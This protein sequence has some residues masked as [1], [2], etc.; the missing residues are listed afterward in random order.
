[1]TNTI[2]D[3]TQDSEVIMLV[4]SN[5]EHAHPV[6]G[7]Q[8]R[9]AVQRGAKLIV[10]DPRDI[11]LSRQAD[12]HLKLRPGTNIAF[13]NGMMHIFIEED[14]ID[15]EFIEKRTEHFEEIT[16]V[17][18]EY[19]PERVAEICRIDPDKLREA[20]R[21]YA[22]AKTA[23]VIYCLGVTE[24]HTG[25]HG[26]ISLSNM[27]MMVGKFGKRGCGLNPLRGQN[28]VQGACDMGA[29]PKQF[30]GYQNLDI[31][32]VMDKF[33]KAWGT[34]L[35]HEIG[36]KATECFGKMTTGEIRGLFI[37]GEDPMR[38][39]PNTRHVLRAL[40]SLDFLVVDEL[41]MT[42]TAKL[43]DVILPGRSYAEKEGTF[44]N[45]ERRVQRVRKAVEIE[46]ETRE[47]TWIFTE[48]MNR[49]GYP[50]PHL[51]AA[52]IMDEIA[53]V[54]PNFA[55]ISHER[56]DSTEVAGRGL[57]WPCRSKDKP[58]TEIMHVGKFARGL[59]CFIPTRHI[60]SMELPDEDYPIIMMT[61]RILYH[62]NACAMTDK[63]EGLN[64]MAPDS[65]IELNTEDA[66]KLEVRDGDMVN[67]S[68]RRGKIQAR[69]VVSEKTNPGECWMPFH[70]I[71]G[72]NWLTSDALDS[73]SK[74]PEYKVC[75]V[76]VEKIPE[77][78][79]MREMSCV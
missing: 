49:M 19:T 56:L 65:F 73:I 77:S 11:D 40:S 72:A 16:K 64:E 45:T 32:E 29:D 36:T 10:V 47:D 70:Y 31:P 28:N 30:P 58:G 1:M 41:F 69:A 35:N 52:E 55:G 61:G 51:T 75:T 63:V 3:I 6:I 27:V 24:H 18:A 15:H 5:P 9:Q 42:E 14:L 74:T 50:Q 68:S 48:I 25:T 13:A 57:Q 7:M 12:I 46:G 66:E 78:D 21:L 67:V 23:P 17:V 54:T 39:D 8:I 2:A 60:P 53:S 71:G 43:A 79:Y 33:E 37:F 26:V 22:K 44:T 38:T 59:G 76:K 20:A 4:G 34:K 62:Y